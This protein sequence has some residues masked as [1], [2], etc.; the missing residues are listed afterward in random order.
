MSEVETT[1][2]RIKKHQGVEGSFITNASR[3]ATRSNYIGETDKG[4]KLVNNVLTLTEKAKNLVRDLDPSNDLSFLRIKT[5][6]KE[7]M[8]APDSNFMYI[9]LQNTSKDRTEDM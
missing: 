8:V 2:A 4:G 1:I 3:Q 6:Y 5:K 7:I 9:V